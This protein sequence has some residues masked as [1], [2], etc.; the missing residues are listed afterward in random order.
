MPDINVTIRMDANLKRQ[1]E[2]FFNDLGMSLNT[3][4][5]VFTKQ[6]LREQ[7]IPFEIMKSASNNEGTDSYEESEKIVREDA[8][9]SRYYSFDDLLEEMNLK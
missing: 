4:F 1:A 6:A 5:T 8:D 7:K 2:A 9:Y 3:A